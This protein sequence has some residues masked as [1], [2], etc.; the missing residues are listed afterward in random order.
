MLTLMAINIQAARAL[1]YHTSAMVDQ[2]D[3]L[4]G[5]MHTLSQ[6]IVDGTSEM[7]GSH[8]EEVIAARDRRVPLRRKMG[9]GWDVAYAAL[10]LHSDE[11]AFV[12]GVALVVDGGESVSWGS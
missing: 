8:R 12:T 1:L 4:I 6:M 10:F 9:T 3:G 5:N 11:A 2:A 7:V